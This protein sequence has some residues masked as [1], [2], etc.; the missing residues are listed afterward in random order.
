MHQLVSTEPGLT[1]SNTNLGGKRFNDPANAGKNRK[2]NENILKR[3]KQI[4]MLVM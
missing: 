1:R 2:L 4:G 3:A